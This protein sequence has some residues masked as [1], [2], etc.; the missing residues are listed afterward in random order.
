MKIHALPAELKKA[1]PKRLRFVL[2]TL[3]GR[4][5]SHADKLIVYLGERAARLAGLVAARAKL[6]ALY[7]QFAGP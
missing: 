3:A 4:I 1:R 7:A 5:V 6:A 2:F